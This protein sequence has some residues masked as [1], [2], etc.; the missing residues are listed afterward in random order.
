MRMLRV[1][2][3]LA[4]EK[5]G[6]GKVLFCE[7]GTGTGKT[8]AYLSAA[9]ELLERDPQARVMIAAPSFAL[10][11]Q[12]GETLAWL[13]EVAGGAVFLAGQNEWVS[14]GALQRLIDDDGAGLELADRQA[15]LRWMKRGGDGSRP[16]WSMG[17]LMAAFPRA[18]A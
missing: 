6:Q 2:R 12:I 1:M 18:Q 5:E 17:S 16:A 13:G 9:V 11:Q 3:K 14:E 4:H 10:V 15:L 8:A 7:A